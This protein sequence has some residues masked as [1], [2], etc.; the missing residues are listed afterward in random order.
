MTIENVVK[1]ETIR[2]DSMERQRQMTI[3]P[4]DIRN[5]SPPGRKITITDGRKPAI[6][7]KRQSI[8]GAVEIIN[9]TMSPTQQT[10]LTIE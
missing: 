7:I 8:P 2:G 1:I 5:E 9:R 10:I 4:D 3:K 6:N